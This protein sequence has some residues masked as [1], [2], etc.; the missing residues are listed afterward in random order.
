MTTD[1]ALEQRAIN[2][3]RGLAMDAPHAARSGHQ[4]TAM[5]LA[6]A[7]HVLWTRIMNYDSSA[8]DWADRDRFI[9]SP[10][11]ASILLYSL[12]H[13]TG[14]GLTL[15]D[16]KA[17]RQWGSQTPGHPEVGHT[18]GV[19]VTTGPL[20]QGFANGIGMA[21]AEA[22]LRARFG[23]DLCDHYIY[24][25]VS[26]GD[27]AEGISHESA[28]LAGH[29]GLGRLIYIYDDN[30]VSIDGHT[31]ISLSDD[32]AGR[33]R[34]YG[35]DVTEAGEVGENLD[36]IEA[37]ISNAKAVTDKP[38]IIII[39]TFIGYP[40][41]EHTDD[42]HAH[43]YVFKDD[44]IAS[45]KAA[46]DMPDEP[47][48]VPASVLDYYRTAGARGAPVRAA[49]EAAATAWAGDRASYDACIAGTGIGDWADDLPTFEVGEK[50][51]TRVA[52]GQAMTAILD[53][54]PGIMG[55]GADL[56][57]NTGTTIAGR[58]VF[59]RDD[60][61][62][63]QLFYG[64]R[65]HGMGAIM[66]GM[67]LHGGV[68]PVGGTF[69]VFSDYMRGAVRLAALSQAKSI[70]VWT[71]DSVGVGEDGPTHQPVEQV[72]SLRAI[73]G[74]RVIRPADANEASQA[75]K[76]AIS[77]TGPTALI[78]S[79]QGLTVLAGTAGGGLEHG[80]YVLDDSDAAPDLVLVATGSE[81]HVCVD[82]AA[83]LR[84]E[85]I[86]TRVVSLP[87]W[88]LFDQQ[89]PKYQN[90]VLP[91]GVPTVAVEAGVSFGWHR[92]AD[93]VVGID[94]FGASAPATRIMEEFGIT[95]ENVAAQA[96][97]LLS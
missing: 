19:E 41:P 12:L 77:L 18:A 4:G 57:G 25:L 8:P 94:R 53:S 47:F 42:P 68:V 84:A 71:H 72:A 3:I 24:G 54:V 79:R 23:S 50:L 10:G 85:G 93:R 32:A 46:M 62:G 88:E 2:T 65:E 9:L 1:P 30:H 43:G 91:K 87:C 34:A 26:D 36:A 38:S 39:R 21:I 51:A 75:W 17:F 92:W 78:M 58:G 86:D 11:H 5:A 55:G 27:L 81:V 90:D 48:H 95:A 96:R 31:E 97:E 29:L 20:G 33:F 66:N 16:L 52:G 37:A 59:T 89:S 63:R 70:F 14:F 28:S 6:P 74:L 82:A 80:G 67:A 7:A 44:E 64:I 60:Y 61:S 15:D 49:Q 73:P 22:S 69:L 35:W 45:T 56:T 76:A 83:T 13:L 40:S